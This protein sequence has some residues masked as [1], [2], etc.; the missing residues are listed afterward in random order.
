ML[1]HRVK[2]LVQLQP[3][4]PAALVYLEWVRK[5]RSRKMMYLHFTMDDNLSLSEDIKARYRS[6][7]SGVFYQRYILGLWTVAEGLVYDMFDR[8]KHIVDE[9]PQLSPKSTYVACDFGT[10]NATVFLLLQNRQMQTAGSSPGSITTA[11]ANRSGK[12][13]WASMLQTSRCG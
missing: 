8:K 3:G 5:C 11:A 10:Q 9:L 4:Q 1:C 13:P 6:Q 7:Y 2:V 12:R